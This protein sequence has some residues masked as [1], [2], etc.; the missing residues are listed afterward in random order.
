MSASCIVI[1]A[2]YASSRLPAKPLAMIAGK[3][4]LRR[5]VEVAN[6]AAS[7]RAQLV[8]AVDHPEIESHAKELASGPDIA[9]VMT[10][11]ALASG[12]DRTWAAV[13]QLPNLP[14]N[15]LNYQGD[16][17]LTPWWILQA[18]LDALEAP[19]AAPVVTPVVQLSWE[20][21]DR[22]RQ[23]K[24]TSPFSGTTAICQ[25]DGRAL[26]FSKQIIPAIRKE[27]RAHP[28]SPVL[29]HIGLYG[30][31][32]EA[33]RQYVSLPPSPYEILE[34]LEQLRFLENNIAIQTVKVDYYGVP[35]SSGVD[36]EQDR[37]QAEALI[38][39]HGEFMLRDP[40][41]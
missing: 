34:G 9:V 31:H 24:T 30:F 1:P 28:M 11:P 35:S 20:A 21:L 2:R 27:V 41:L 4:M 17:P 19:G 5:V 12:T 6:N 18:M 36:T 32:T 7:G 22:L 39:A 13:Q 29:R 40:R 14:K 37:A 23:S 38:A 33:L 15:I 16:S 3:T 25:P 26:W 10:D 8:I